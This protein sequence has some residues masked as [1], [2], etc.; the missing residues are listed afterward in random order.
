M[1]PYAP[2]ALENVTRCPP[3]REEHPLLRRAVIERV[4]AEL[5]IAGAAQTSEVLLADVERHADYLERC[6]NEAEAVLAGDLGAAT[7]LWLLLRQPIDP[8][9]AIP[10]TV[11]DEIG[12]DEFAA[13][14]PAG[15]ET[16]QPGPPLPILMP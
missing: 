9:P 14:P 10:A 6:A 4:R 2:P 3:T 8:G 16:V 12:T 7:R 5:T 1:P 15:E 13:A 11:L